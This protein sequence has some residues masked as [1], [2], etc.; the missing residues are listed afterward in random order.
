MALRLSTTASVAVPT[1][2]VAPDL[3]LLDRASTALTVGDV[4]GYRPLVTETGAIADPHRRYV[5]R[6][7][8]I[9]LGLQASGR[10]GADTAAILLAT[11]GT[12]LDALAESPAEP[13][14]LNL[15]G[16]LLYKMGA[17][18]G[19]E[20]LFDAAHALDPEVENLSDN[21]DTV[22]ALRR[23]N[24]RMTPPA[25]I[26]RQVSNLERRAT[27]L[28]R[29]AKPAAA[30]SISLC[31]IVRDEEA[32]LARALASAKDVVDEIVVV[33]T[34][35]QDRTVEI[36]REHGATVLTHAWDDDFSAARNAGVDAATSDWILFLDADET[37][38][39]DDAPRLRDLARRTWREGFKLT[40]LNHGDGGSVT[41]T[42]VLRLFR[43]RPEHR[44]EGRVHEGVL[45]RMPADA[46]ER[47]ETPGV[48]I[49]HDGYLAS[50]RAAKDKSRRNLEL[51]ERQRAEG[52]ASPYLAFNLG[53]EHLAAGDPATALTH[54]AQ[55]IAALG[56]SR[57]NYSPVLALR[58]VQA[59]RATGRLDDAIEN[60]E[61]GLQAFA[62]F[63][64]LVLEQALA[65]RARGDAARAEEL[66]RR[67]LELGDAPSS[68]AATVGAGTFVAAAELAD[69]V[70][71]D[72]RRDEAVALLDRVVTEH[73]EHAVRV[74]VTALDAR[75]AA[76]DVDG[77]V[78]LLPLLD[79]VET[80]GSRERREILATLYLERGFVDSAADEWSAA[81][82]EHGPDA[83]ALTGLSRVAAARGNAEDAE[84]FAEGARELTAGGVA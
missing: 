81:C 60:A 3:A 68:Y 72:G 61:G 2:A 24:Q 48:R 15:A 16:V 73:P 1:A 57:V 52:D 49:D 84:L 75:L 17:Q 55:A 37:L 34:G 67:C 58:Y 30:A 59:L 27:E 19:A 26:A 32:T 66:L 6:R 62:G 25:S 83:A 22:K 54:F 35:S 78:A 74:L 51:L 70:A 42:D 21:R 8:L 77:F 29:K 33:D 31:M 40:I 20:T 12:A 53:S 11:G 64:D 79:R 41:A 39:A 10:A 13:V 56:T 43:N 82:E 47:V 46:P 4:E 18:R 36:A 9:E 44:F 76:V 38:V 45:H 5:A 80:L 14:L 50:T 69:L 28:A 63:T 23:R 7:T 71:A 65:H